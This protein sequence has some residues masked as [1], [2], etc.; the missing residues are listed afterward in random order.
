MNVRSVWAWVLRF[1][2]R[3]ALARVPILAAS[4]AYYATFSL[5]P[6]LLLAFAGF[7]FA[8]ARYPDLRGEILLF[9]Q[10]AIEQTFPS[11][12]ELLNATLEDLKV[13]V[14]DRFQTNAG[15]TGLIG[16]VGL[17]W[18]AS[19]FFTALQGA[20]TLA[21]P[22][23]RNRN[24][25]MQRF[26]GVLSLFTLAPLMLLLMLVGAVISSL[27]SVPFLSQVQLYSSSLLPVLGA[28]GLFALSYRFLPAHNPGWRA[29][30]LAALPTALVWQGARLS[31][32]LLTPISSFQAT[33][34][35]LAG[36][37]LLLA[38]VYLSMQIFLAGGVLVSLL[39]RDRIPRADEDAKCVDD[40][41]E[42][43]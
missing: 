24:V 31:L 40:P 10:S 30:L 35:I 15:V 18:G 17:I 37:L 14:L 7:G 11:A 28:F 4:L 43:D 12:S 22:G 33:Y 20:L 19:G 1:A 36:F 16:F 27:S 26:V 32:G 29:S 13:S 42:L 21:I 2:D 23:T 8:L 3:L 34:G 9:L 39:E 6:L 5:F 25:W 38:W 41:D